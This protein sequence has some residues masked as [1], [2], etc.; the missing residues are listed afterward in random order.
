MGRPLR[1]IPHGA[2]AGY[3]GDAPLS[4]RELEVVRLIGQGC[5]NREIAVR[6]CLSARTVDN[7]V[8]RILAKVGAR[9][10]TALAVWAYRLGLAPDLAGVLAEQG[11]EAATAIAG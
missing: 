1:S 7:H 4:R 8:H 3:P 2:C 6:L 10:R 5:T 11:T 9:S